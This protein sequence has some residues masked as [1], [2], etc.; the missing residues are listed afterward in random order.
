MTQD[1]DARERA[2]TE[3]FEPDTS[4]LEDRDA[5]ADPDAMT[6]SDLAQAEQSRP[7]LPG[8]TPDGLDDLDEEI[9]RQAEDLPT[10]APGRL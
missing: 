8:E 7:T 10:D 3:P 9:R 2:D 4:D 6:L 5:S 1:D